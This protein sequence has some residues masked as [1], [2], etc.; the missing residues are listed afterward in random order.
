MLCCPGENSHLLNWLL[1]LG[2]R[3]REWEFL[4][5]S[6]TRGPDVSDGGFSD[7]GLLTYVSLACYP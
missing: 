6:S 1:R 7:S 4:R 3:V 2:H 5:M